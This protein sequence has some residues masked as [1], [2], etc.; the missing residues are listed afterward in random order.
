MFLG[1]AGP[2]CGGKPPSSSSSR[3]V[4]IVDGFETMC[5]YGAGTPGPIRTTRAADVRQ[6]NFGSVSCGKAGTQPCPDGS[7]CQPFDMLAGGE[8]VCRLQCD[9]TEPALRC[10]KA[11]DYCACDGRCLPNPATMTGA[12]TPNNSTCPRDPALLQSIQNDAGV[13]RS[14]TW[15][16]EC[17]NGSRCDQRTGV[18][19][20]DCQS[21]AN[22]TGGTVCNCL[23]QCVAADVAAPAPPTSQPKLSVFPQQSFLFPKS[24]NSMTP[25]GTQNTQDIRIDLTAPF[26]TVTGSA[27]PMGPQPKLTVQP[28]IH[29]QVQCPGDAAF[30]AAGASCDL[31]AWTYSRANPDTDPFRASNIV[32]IR[33]VGQPAT[34]PPP[35]EWIVRL[36]GDGITGVPIDVS[37]RYDDST[38]APPA[39][40]NPVPSSVAAI[41]MR[42]AP[43]GGQ[44][45]F[46]GTVEVSLSDNVTFN[47]PVVARISN[48]TDN[49]PHLYI[50][51]RSRLLSHTGILK[52]DYD[53]ALTAAGSNQVV[54]RW[55]TFNAKETK[56]Y[57]DSVVETRSLAQ[58]PESTPASPQP[59][60]GQASMSFRSILP[61]AGSEDL[62]SVFFSLEPTD[63]TAFGGLCQTSQ[64]CSGAQFCDESGFCVDPD[65][66]SPSA[67]VFSAPAPRA[68]VEASSFRAWA[69]A[70]P[71]ISTSKVPPGTVWCAT[72][73]TEFRSGLD[74]MTNPDQPANNGTRTL[75]TG[76]MPCLLLTNADDVLVGDPPKYKVA[77]VGPFPFA[78]RQDLEDYSL[79]QH[80]TNSQLFDK[81]W[82]DLAEAAPT[83][84]SGGANSAKFNDFPE[85][86]F[87]KDHECV[88]LGP[89]AKLWQ[90]PDFVD[91]PANMPGVE[92]L[93]VRA[94]QQWL[95]VHSFVLRQG[96]ETYKLDRALSPAPSSGDPSSS[97]AIPPTLPELM[98]RME[99][100][101]SMILDKTVVAAL[102]QAP[103]PDYRFDLLFGTCNPACPTGFKCKA[104]QS[105]CQLDP[106][107]IPTQ[108]EDQ[109]IGLAPSM[110]DALTSYLLVSEADLQKTAKAAYSLSQ[111]LDLSNPPAEIRDALSRYGDAMR[112]AVV[113]KSAAQ[114]IYAA[115]NFCAP[116]GAGG[117]L[118]KYGGWD[119]PWT[120]A[121]QE[122]S[123]AMRA[124]TSA[125]AQLAAGENPLGIAEDDL[126]LFFGDVTGVNS[127]YFASSDYLLAGWADP[128]VKSAQVALDAARNEWRAERDRE[129]ANDLRTEDL[130]LRYGTELLENCGPQTVNGVELSARDAIDTFKTQGLD[131]RICFIKEGPKCPTDFTSDSLDPRLTK[132]FTVQGIQSELCRID[133]LRQHGQVS[134]PLRSCAEMKLQPPLC[135]DLG[136]VFQTGTAPLCTP[137]MTTGCVPRCD[138][139][140]KPIRGGQKLD[141]Y[142]HCPGAVDPAECAEIMVA[143][144][145]TCPTKPCLSSAPAGST[146]YQ[147]SLSGGGSCVDPNDNGPKQAAKNACL[148]HVG[149]STTRWW[150]SGDSTLWKTKTS[151]PPDRIPITLSPDK[152]MF[153]VEGAPPVRVSEL[154]SDKLMARRGDQLLWAQARKA[155]RAQGYLFPLVKFD[156]QNL[157]TSCLQG[158]MG[159]AAKNITIAVLDARAAATELQNGIENF[160]DAT[161]ACD[162]IADNANQ[163]KSLYN[164]YVQTKATWGQ[165]MD[166]VGIAEGYASMAMSGNVAAFGSQLLGTMARNAIDTAEQQFK[167]FEFLSGLNEKETACRNQVDAQYRNLATLRLRILR[168]LETVDAERLRFKTLQDHN[169][170]NLNTGTAALERDKDRHGPG[171][172]YHFWYTERIERF[173]RELEW[174]RRLTFLA[175]RAVEYELQQT[176]DLRTT[177]LSASHPDE[178]EAAL[179]I[180]RQEQGGRSINRRRPEEGSIVLSLRD[181]ILQVQDRSDEPSGE[182][183]WTPAMRFKGRLSA[184]QFA[185]WDKNGNY[186]GQGIP[187]NLRESGVL[188]NRCGERLWRVT[189]TVQGDGLSPLEPGTPLMLL[190][191]NTAMSQYC[192]GKAPMTKSLRFK[193]Q[194]SSLRSTSE[195]LKGKAGRQEDTQGF[196]AA[197]LYPWFNV[198]R[199]DFYSAD[200]RK[201]SSEELAGRALYGDYILLFPKQILSASQNP[202]RPAFPLNNVEDVLLRMEYLS[203]DNLPQ[204]QQAEAPAPL[205]QDESWSGAPKM[206]AKP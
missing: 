123:E 155:C 203:V 199:F 129:V 87:S 99:A 206:L 4:T 80:L 127:R 141:C 102:H 96:L 193:Y 77:N 158:R 52:L 169:V 172:A 8:G 93:I 76:D 201:G 60:L 152:T 168:Q 7:Y 191:Q 132:E 72:K 28:D 27:G 188:E 107:A 144:G 10:A 140:A 131:P 73:E 106:L 103:N 150:S 162:E 65:P 44:A 48:G 53:P 34:P 36:F 88:S 170:L 55:V 12:S 61:P 22:C 69:N 56:I 204:V 181:D 92:R 38:T 43:A 139:R 39:L 35:S 198:R 86:V 1:L 68:L 6:V 121:T 26:L 54:N 137:G 171:F 176:V 125:A 84:P 200:Y 95:K 160:K 110:L 18:C 64:G 114:T 74:L 151:P 108:A 50:N 189:A 81:C 205:L 146:C 173:H 109:M 147:T 100:G 71:R 161:K 20:W 183:N 59:I 145:T 119:T 118:C 113:V 97:A 13:S 24:T 157:D 190:K 105:G 21:N 5:M 182:R 164:N 186:L 195:L 78:H 167:S 94:G 185:V 57:F 154:L 202:P 178:L 58:A 15:D 104:D 91:L 159:D 46:R 135:Q 194:V 153:T 37:F 25:W 128:A 111:Q 67:A 192:E 89:V 33:V 82:S 42:N 165:T 179:R 3:R 156:F 2:S 116:D 166:Y 175:M 143:T 163:L 19:K 41:A 62:V 177:I 49:K 142:N 120:N 174:A 197:A 31:T 90:Y 32:Q 79:R 30:R 9:P 63:G 126:P 187:F 124:A 122:L 130:A 184:S 136:R 180:L 11:T 23:G 40:S 29:L 101:L 45:S 83:I 14:C 16:D 98:Q 85:A 138:C 75:S 112:L 17:P 134:F 148:D 149:T 47:V 133:Y 115:S 196:T 66:R 117:T 51:D 70:G